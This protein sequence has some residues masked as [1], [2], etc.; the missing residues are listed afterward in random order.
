MEQQLKRQFIEKDNLIYEQ[1]A[2]CQQ[3]E[4]ERQQQNPERESQRRANQQQQQEFRHQQRH[5]YWQRQQRQY[6][7][8]WRQQRQQR[9]E[10]QQHQHEQGWKRDIN[11]YANQIEAQHEKDLQEPQMLSPE[12]L[13]QREQKRQKHQRQQ[14]RRR[15]QRHEAHR[16][17][18]TER[19]AYRTERKEN[20]PQQ[21]LHRKLQ[22]SAFIN[23]KRMW[24][25]LAKYLRQRFSVKLTLVLGDWSAT[26]VRWHAPTPGV[27]MRRMLVKLGFRLLHID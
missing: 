18:Q 9:R 2:E 25:Q 24:S 16:N 6:R 8:D 7:R 21:P 23:T 4:T 5:E 27:G 10:Y 12:K 13:Q 20:P 17:N 26:N 3:Q 15:Q 19:V 1:T 11:N 14:H 22:Q